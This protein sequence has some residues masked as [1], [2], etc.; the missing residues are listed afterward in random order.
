MTNALTTTLGQALLLLAEA[1]TIQQAHQI[2][3]MAAAGEEYAKE[4][5]LSIEAFNYAA[6][7]KLRAERRL[8]EILKETPKN[9]GRAEPGPR[10]T[11]NEPRSNGAPPTLAEAGIT[12]KQSS[13]AQKIANIPAEEFE[14]HIAD[15]KAA[16]KPI[17]DAALLKQQQDAER[18][19][20]REQKDT[21]ARQ[22]ETRPVAT[23]AC[24]SDW[25]PQQEAA[26][27][28][29]TD[30]PYSTDVDNVW[31][32][33]HDWL[34]A[35]LDK[36][37]ATGRAYVCIGAYPDELAAYLNAPRQHMTLANILVWTYRNTLGPSPKL[38]YKL[39][40]QAILYFRGP[41]APPLDCPEMTEQFT[42]HDINAP[43]G[44]LADRY[45]TWQKPDKL[46][47]RLIRHSTQPG[48]TVIDPFVGTGTFLLAA[49]RLGRNATGCDISPD[50][51][52][53]AEQRGVECK[54]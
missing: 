17:T 20:E 27:L 7:I 51:L 31:T 21:E 43:D 41:D 25:L 1:K 6:E 32:F 5:N 15:K 26:D 28:L 54:Q 23:H 8:G 48:Q 16:G 47:E 13:T 36:V 19:K 45:H 12:K 34:P 29:I 11:N 42:V 22:Q 50:M 37:K 2:V 39:N 38:D 46:A 18:K 33:A 44:R 53:I 30:P 52:A 9:S 40:W 24:W 14:Q 4:H 49:A 3:S 35:A 10:G